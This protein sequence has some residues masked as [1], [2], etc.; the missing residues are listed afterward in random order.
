ME[1]IS[2]WNFNFQVCVQEKL[3]QLIWGVL[4]GFS[5]RFPST[6]K[7]RKAFFWTDVVIQLEA[8]YII[9]VTLQRHSPV[10]DSCQS[11]QVPGVP[12]PNEVTKAL[13]SSLSMHACCIHT[14]SYKYN[15]I[16]YHTIQCDTSPSLEVMVQLSSSEF[17]FHWMITGSRWLSSI[18]NFGRVAEFHFQTK[19]LSSKKG[20]HVCFLHEETRYGFSIHEEICHLRDFLKPLNQSPCFFSI[21]SPRGPQQHSHPL[22]GVSWNLDATGQMNRIESWMYLTRCVCVCTSMCT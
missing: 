12:Q 16:R 10:P 17:T 11:W 14:I 19:G 2:K 7:F 4:V 1:W 9:A 6:E 8:F 3:Q 22:P 20:W 18:H 13:T 5:P 15:T 21:L